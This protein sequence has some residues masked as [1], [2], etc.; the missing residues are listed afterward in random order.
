MLNSYNLINLLSLIN[1][2]RELISLL[3]NPFAYAQMK[4]IIEAILDRIPKSIQTLEEFEECLKK[5]DGLG[6]DVISIPFYYRKRIR[7]KAA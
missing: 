5:L 2:G 3:N 7:Y 6:I 1:A 4:A